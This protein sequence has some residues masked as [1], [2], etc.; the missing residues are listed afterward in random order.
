MVEM[1]LDSRPM[2]SPRE[3]QTSWLQFCFAM[4]GDLPME[5]ISVVYADDAEAIT[6]HLVCTCAE[7]HLMTLTHWCGSDDEF[8]TFSTNNEANLVV[9]VPFEPHMGEM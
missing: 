9:R 5:N 7:R 3:R 2:P 1:I 8:Y 4:L 6:V